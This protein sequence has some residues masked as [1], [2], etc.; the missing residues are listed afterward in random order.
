MGDATANQDAV[1]AFLGD[2]STHGG[3][4]ARRIDTHAAAVFLKLRGWIGCDA[5]HPR[6]PT[7]PD[8]DRELL[9]G[10]A[11]QLGLTPA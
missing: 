3:Q 6:S 7:R 4:P 5:T 9:R 11:A 1:F 2:P 8:S 10:V